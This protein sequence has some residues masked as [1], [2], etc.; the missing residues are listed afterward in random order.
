MSRTKSGHH[1]KLACPS[2]LTLALLVASC[3]AV[4]GNDT[5]AGSGSLT[6]PVVKPS[7]ELVRAPIMADAKVGDLAAGFTNAGFDLMRTQPADTNLIFSPLSIGHAL[8][9]ARAAADDATGAAID[10]AFGLPAGMEAHDAWNTLDAAIA[11]SNVTQ[12]APDGS[13]TPVVTVSD[14]LWPSTAASPNQNWVD[15]MA[16]HH[17]ADVETIDVSDPEASRS[18]INDWVSEQTQ[19]LIPELLPEN[20][21]T[22]NTVLV[23]TDTI[24]FKADWR[25]VFGKYGPESGA[26]TRLDG[27]MV[28][29]SYLVDLEQ[30]GIRGLG[31]GYSGAEIPYLGDDYAMLL[32]IPDE[33][34]F[35]EVR[36]RLSQDLLAEIDN[37]FT[38]GPY[39]LRMPKWE[40][41]STINLA[42][43]LTELRIA[44]GA[45]PGI[46]PG[47]FLAEAI[48]GADITVD[49]NGTVAAAAT[50]LG[51]DESG[52]GEPEIVIAAERPF[53]YVVR[54]VESGAVL[55][56]GQVVD[57]TS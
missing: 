40:A 57:P 36:Q 33:G 17:G 30:S 39:E 48:H 5:S 51:F 37:T 45:Y 52:P 49:E 21:I 16:T 32:I 3:G 29:L 15:L 18:R 50:A 55:F 1:R 8:L 11:D 53:F 14:R 44:P 43:W 31:D 38:T 34:R 22:S 28:D 6:G 35:D 12:T 23:L 27:S 47:V 19:T 56:A 54:H 24:Y 20:F 2:F 9:M 25:S 7:A 13:R 42:D 10:D 41:S 46:G 26:F 4:P